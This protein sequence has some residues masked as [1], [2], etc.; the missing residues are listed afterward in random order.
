[1]ENDFEGCLWQCHHRLM[2]CITF[3]ESISKVTA[4]TSAQVSKFCFWKAI[5]GTELLHPVQ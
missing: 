1:M 3:K 4:A 5:P 2:Q